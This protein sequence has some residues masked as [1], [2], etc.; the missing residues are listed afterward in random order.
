MNRQVFLF[1]LLFFV[2]CVFL[3]TSSFQAMYIP[4]DISD[5]V[6]E[7]ALEISEEVKDI[8]DLN[9]VSEA[10]NHH[11]MTMKGGIEG[12]LL[13]T[14]FFELILA[15][16]EAKRKYQELDDSDIEQ[17]LTNQLN[18]RQ[19]IHS[20]NKVDVDSEDLHLVIEVPIINNDEKKSE[21]TQILQPDNKTNMSEKFTDSG[22]YGEATYEFDF[23]KFPNANGKLDYTITVI[24]ISNSGEKKFDI[25]LSNIDMN[26][27]ELKEF[28]YDDSYFKFDF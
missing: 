22:Y 25:N 12:V 2:L 9:M 17:I 3:F 1:S 21:E 7:E 18:I 26:L 20:D 4:E 27:E 13:R 19:S 8:S 5:E 15:G 23:E 10:T 6:I 11:Y 28:E 16:R 24:S 14:P